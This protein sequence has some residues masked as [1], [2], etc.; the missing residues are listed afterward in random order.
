MKD[1]HL[2]I[3][4]FFV[5]ITHNLYAN[6]V[7]DT[8]TE[9]Q[10]KIPIVIDGEQVASFIGKEIDKIRVYAIHNGQVVLVPFQIDQRD[11]DGHWIW[12]SILNT[13]KNKII[14]H[15][16]DIPL[17]ILFFDKNDQIVFMSNDAGDKITTS[18]RKINYADI[19][20]V[21]IILKE[22]ISPKWIYLTH[23]LSDVPPLST[24][25]YMNYHPNTNSVSSPVYHLKYS[26][27]NIAVMDKMMVAG[28][29]V[30]DKTIINGS[31]DLS[32]LLFNSSI[33]FNES[34]IK[35][36]S[37]GYIQGPI[38]IIKEFVTF[39]HLGAGI[40]SI[41][42]AVEHRFYPYHTEVPIILTKNFF[43]KNMSITI[44]SNY[45]FS[46]SCQVYNQTIETHDLNTSSLHE[47]LFYS[48]ILILNNSSYSM[49]TLL[50]IPTA[51]NQK[52]ITDTY[53]AQDNKNKMAG[54]HLKTKD[55]FPKGQHEI[56]VISF[57]SDKPDV[58]KSAYFFDKHFS[59]ESHLL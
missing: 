31:I 41:S 32:L 18:S 36:Q 56:K 49:L 48:K 57:F 59:I 46:D 35:A 17:E 40:K 53:I 20:E 24:K 37:T 16:N 10:I 12:N 45:P 47:S 26:K 52:L 2:I 3:G 7:S 19:L 30:M 58:Y 11:Q 43:V 55:D 22:S 50:K 54:F 21:K 5:L 13:H 39:I 23:H 4:F 34:E 42:L 15:D 38:R 44:G 9:Q 25:S 28:H 51:L 33:D 27:K 14:E 29:L 1:I 6:S 8:K